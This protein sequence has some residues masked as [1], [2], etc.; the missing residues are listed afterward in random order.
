MVPNA[1][2]QN[3]PTRNPDCAK[4]Y[5]RPRMP[6][7]TVVPVSVNA[8]AQNFL[9]IVSSLCLLKGIL[10]LIVL[11]VLF[12]GLLCGAFALSTKPLRR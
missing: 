6:A 1:I 12:F 11:G 9:F 10:F 2:S 5:G 4:T 7:P 3:T 8:A